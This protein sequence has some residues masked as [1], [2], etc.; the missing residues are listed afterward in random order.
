[1]EESLYEVLGFFGPS[2]LGIAGGHSTEQALENAIGFSSKPPRYCLPS[3]D[4]FVLAE[5][6]GVRFYVLGPPRNEQRIKRAM[7]TKSGKETYISNL[8]LSPE[9][10]FMMAAC[11]GVAEQTDLADVVLQE[12]ARPFDGSWCIPKEQANDISFFREHYLGEP[13]SQDDSWRNIDTAW[14]GTAS[15][16]ALQLDTYTNN[17]SLVLAIEFTETGKVFLF[18][19]DAQVGNWLSWSDQSWQVGEGAE[20]K[21]ITAEDLL[22]RTI[23]YKVGHHGSHNATLR[24]NG[25]EL[26]SSPELIALVPV[27]HQM[28]LKKRWGGMPFPALLNRLMDKTGGRV[29]RIDDETTPSQRPAP[30]G[31]PAPVWT[32]FQQNVKRSPDGLYYEVTFPELMDA[33]NLFPT[34]STMSA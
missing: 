4:P 34:R 11:R 15:Q 16:L 10:A 24:T 17:T 18:P 14:L 29:L 26:M 25:L 2:A 27:D 31:T 13:G 8:A 3:D 20:R 19:A 1:V 5:L 30:E 12:L 7:P 6:P 22:R 28:A 23:L 9:T 32:R 21:E 33:K